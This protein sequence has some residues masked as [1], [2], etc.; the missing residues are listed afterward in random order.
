MHLYFKASVIKV[1]DT[2]TETISNL[3]I[4]RL[5]VATVVSIMNAKQY[6]MHAY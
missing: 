3:T 5:G 2:A 1:A 4:Q 6:A